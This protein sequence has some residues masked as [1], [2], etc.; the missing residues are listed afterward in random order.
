MSTL[1]RTPRAHSSPAAS[2]TLAP[3]FA[4]TLLPGALATSL[5]LITAC[6]TVDAVAQQTVNPGDIIVERTVTPRDPFVPV[7]RDQDPVAVRATTFPANS[8]N[9]AI[10]QLVGD[11]DLTNAHGSSGVAETGVLNGSGMQAVTQ[12]LSGRATGN[13]VALNSGAIG[14][15]APGIGGTISSSVT[16]ALAP[17]SNVLSGTLGGLK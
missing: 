10:A 11:T 12:I 5:A 4:F 2:S 7:P 16:G 8:F 15:S 3:G 1:Y 17:L 6:F 13:N 9:P 14:T